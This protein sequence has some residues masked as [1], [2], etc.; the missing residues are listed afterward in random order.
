[1]SSLPSGSFLE[2]IGLHRPELRAWAFYDWANSAF[3]L[4]IITAIFPI[5][6]QKVVAAE[7][8]P[9]EA[10]AYFA[11]ATTIALAIVAISSPLLGALADHLAIRKRLL[12]VFVLIGS[13]A[14]AGLFTVHQG[15]W[16]TGLVYFAIGN[17]CVLLSFVF[18]D[19]LLPHIASA[20]EMDRVS[21]AGYALGYLG[22]GLLLVLILI[23]IG[24]PELFG[25]ADAGAATR[26]GF[27]TVAVWWII[28]TI[29]LMSGVRE[30]GC[31]RTSPHHSRSAALSASFQRLLATLRELR[32]NHR[33]AFLTLL[34]MLIYNDGINTIIRMATIYAATL[35]LPEDKVIVAVLLVQFVGIP[36]SVLFG[37]LAGRI[38]TRPAILVGLGV[39]MII[40][41]IAFRMETIEEFYAVATLVA[42]VQGGTQAMSRS[43]FA[44]LI[45]RVRSSELF[46]FYSLSDKFSGIFGPLIFSLMITL[47]GS[48]RHAVLSVIVFF[49]VGAIILARVNLDEGRRQAE[50][51]DALGAS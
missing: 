22:S 43:L 25:L 32:G 21:A 23:V 36:F 9:E 4:V 39:Y 2:R 37:L 41:I 27:L 12:G 31:A 28:F 14:T 47:T 6:F 11:W 26:V 34:A 17:V 10:T 8:S 50:Q 15:D 18:Y 30:P 45:P 16:L 35:Q 7:F 46:G 1:M 20:G 48:S 44:S 13:A 38:G 29:P 24:Q 5:Y 19:S 33:Q 40:P 51:L 3:V 42:M 49:V